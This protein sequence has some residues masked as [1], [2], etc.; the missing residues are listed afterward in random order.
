M[1]RTRDA[2]AI[3]ELST[4][5]RMQEGRVQEQQRESAALQAR[6]MD[7]EG[8]LRSLEMA[9][10][11]SRAEAQRTEQEAGGLREQLEAAQREAQRSAGRCPSR[12]GQ[13]WGLFLVSLAQA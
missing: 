2:A 9:L 8:A 5:L 10:Q 13:V 7:Q 4:A 3:A 12:K 1:T 11:H 6:A